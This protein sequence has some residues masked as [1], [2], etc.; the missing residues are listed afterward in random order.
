MVDQ[1][2]GTCGLNNSRV[3]M[4]NKSGNGPTPGDEDHRV[5][6]ILAEGVERMKAENIQP[7]AIFLALLELVAMF[8]ACDGE[9]QAFAV[10]I[11][12]IESYAQKWSV[13]YEKEKQRIA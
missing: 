1:D 11:K 12:D 4:K 2:A 5:R 7:V 6:E 10:A 8:A 3:P 13:T 9:E